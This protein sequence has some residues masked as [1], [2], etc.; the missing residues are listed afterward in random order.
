[1]LT[2][3]SNTGVFMWILRNFLRAAFFYRSHLVDALG[4][5]VNSR[6]SDKYLLQNSEGEMLRNW[7]MISMLCSQNRN[8][9]R[10][11][12]LRN[13]RTSTLENRNIWF[14][15]TVRAL[16]GYLPRVIFHECATVASVINVTKARFP[17]S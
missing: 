7:D 13:F 10:V 6:Y 4:T 16:P 3:D 1:M 15:Q 8:P 14:K 5:A 11:F 12:F 17:F 9:P 2:R